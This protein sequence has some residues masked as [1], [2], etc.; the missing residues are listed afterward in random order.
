MRYEIKVAVRYLLS[1]RLQ[2]ALI[3]AGV[4]VGILAY[5]FMAALINGLAQ[6]LTEDVIGN[7]A[8]VVLEPPD[9][10]PELLLPPAS[11]QALV[12]VQRADERR[13]EIEGWRPLAR[14]VAAVPGV[15]AVAPQVVGSGFI[16][17][18]EKVVPVSLL[19][20]ESDKVS[21][22]V[23][24]EGSLARGSL[25]LGPEDVLIGVTLADEL[26][27]TAGQRL[28]LESE[29]DRERVLTIRGIFDVGSANLN[30]RVAFVELR[31]AQSLLDLGGAISEIEVKVADIYRAP[32]LGRYLAG[33]TGLEAKDW[34]AENRRLQEALRA[35]ANTGRVIK[36]FSMLT[37]LIGVASV[38]LVS[39]LRHRAE[40]GIL[41]SFGVSRASVR[42]IFL[43]QGGFI[44]V[45]GAGGGA[46]L[47]WLFCLLLREGLR[48]PDGSPG[49]PL[50]P[51]Q[52]EYAMAVLLATA[53]SCLA[54]ALP[55]RAA[56]RV[57]P[58]EVIQQ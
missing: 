58:V 31:T 33:I 35:Q 13:P 16:Q 53:A 19:G 20:V 12:A 46:F 17:R 30:E 23:D 27:L 37:I 51:A 54:A 41:R 9:R 28:R 56:A 25:A 40:I 44:G 24:L 22:I 14:A 52:G 45:A 47:G 5:T 6:R 32:E 8:H 10:S 29:R 15:T 18:G 7:I 50:D 42:A 34:I 43:L 55:A 49:L 1:S 39:V 3:L 21:A 4:A 57:D 11:G 48:R 26:G 36:F 38:L 2:T